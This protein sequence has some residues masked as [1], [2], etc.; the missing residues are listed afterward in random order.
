MYYGLLVCFLNLL[1]CKGD[2]MTVQISI[3]QPAMLFSPHHWTVVISIIIYAYNY[4]YFYSCFTCLSL[5]LHPW[6]NAPD[7]EHTAAS[8]HWHGL[9]RSRDC[10]RSCNT[11]HCILRSFHPRTI[12]DTSCV[13]YQ[14][15]TATV[16]RRPTS[17]S[18]HHGIQGH[19]GKASN[20]FEQHIAITTTPPPL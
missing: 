9:G 16:N 20:A 5:H 13:V 1:W 19:G 18:G 4:S 2:T 10:G 8:T 12:S 7:A 15:P 11:Y 3:C 17:C 6:C 14:S